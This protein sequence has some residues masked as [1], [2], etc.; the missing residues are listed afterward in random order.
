MIRFCPNCET[1]RPLTETFCE[2]SRDGS[3]CH[4]DL[5]TEEV[6]APGVPPTSATT[7]PGGL[8][9]PNGHAVGQGDLICVEC[10]ES[11]ATDPAPPPPQDAPAPAEVTVIEGWRLG[12]RLAS[13][14]AVRERFLSTRD[15]D[16]RSGVL[17]LY[18]VGSEPD[19]AVY[20]I[21]RRLPREHVPEIL[22]TGRW[23]D[24]A[25]EVTEEI[26]GG[27]FSSVNLAR[28]GVT[29]V[30]AVTEQL[31][32][33]LNSLSE[34]GLRHRDLRPGAVLVRATEPLDLVIGGF[35]SARLSEFDLD[36]VSPLE[37][38]RYSAPETVAGGVAAASDWWSLGMLLLEGITGGACFD[39]V[40]DQAFLIH[41][42][43]N[44]VT[45]PGGL[46]P[47][48]ELLLRGL[49]ARD[50]N[51]RWQWPQ[52][53]AWLS[54]EAV[55]APATTRPQPTSSSGPAITLGNIPHHTA[56]AFALA[57]ANVAHWDEARDKFARGAV[58][59][60]AADAGFESK[61][62][63]AL[64][65]IS[66]IEGLSDDLRLSLALKVLHPIMPLVVRGNILSPGWLLD[67]PADGYEI[68]TGAAP[69]FL[70]RLGTE[71]WLT[72]LKERVKAV[73]DR[74]AQ[75]E[76]DL[77]EEDLRGHLL[78]TSVPRFAALWET[79]RRLMPESEH[80]GIAALME[81]RQ[82]SD[83][84][85]ILLLAASVGQFRPATEILD[86]AERESSTAGIG[87]FDRT[88]AESQLARPRRELYRTLDET[89]ENF[90]RCGLATADDWADRFRVNRRMPLARALALLSI[91]KERWK[92]PPKQ[93]YVSTLLDFFSKKI[94]GGI[95]RGP[96]TRMLIG[97][98]AARIDLCELG[99]RRTPASDIIAHLLARGPHTV[100]LDPAAFAAADGL[101]R[102]IRS[103]HSHALLYRRDTGIDGL[104]M[105]FP[106]L[107]MR[108][109]RSNTKP[110]IAPVLL[111]P[112][113]I[114]PEVGNRGHV[115]LAFGRDHD[116]DPDPDLV[117]LNP[118]FEGII[119]IQHAGEWLEA[120]KE[121][122]SRGALSVDAV[123]D[124]FGGLAEPLA[125]E[126]CPLPGKDTKV[127]AHRRELSPSAVL[128]HLTF[129]G[130]AIVK[131]LNDLR[132]QPPAGTGLEAALR[133][134]P[135]QPPPANAPVRVPEVERYFT[136]DSDPSQ[137]ESV[138][139]ARSAPGLVI[140][141]PPGTGKSQTIVNM[142][143]DAIGRG[144][145]LL[146]IC[147]KQAALDV[148][149]K[150]LE[151]EG[152]ENRFV[153][154]S[155]VNRDRMPIVRGVREQVEAIH[156][157]PPAGSPAWR[158]ERIRAAARIEALES[159]LNGHHEALHR[160][161][162]ATGLTYR[163]LLGELIALEAGHAAP[164]D[165]SS[166]RGELGKLDPAQVATLE[167]TCGPLAKYWLP[168]KF[169]DSAL[170]VLKLFSADP[171]TLDTFVQT[172][173]GLVAAE[174]DRD[175]TNE[176]TADADR[177]ED[178][179]P[180]R[181]WLARH[182]GTFRT[183]SDGFCA[184]LPRLLPL[185]RAGSPGRD[186][187]TTLIAEL[188]EVAQ[189]FDEIDTR[190]YRPTLS[191][192]LELTA[193]RELTWL[194]ATAAQKLA[195]P[196]LFGK[197][198]PMRWLAT[199]RLRASL[200]SMDLAWNDTTVTAVLA[201]ARLERALRPL[202]DRLDTTVKAL[203]NGN[204]LS[205]GRAPDTLAELASNLHAVLSRVGDV[206][207]VINQFPDRGR[208]ESTAMAGN[209]AAFASFF[210]RVERSIRRCEARI[211]SLTALEA[212]GPF[213]EEAW[214]EARRAQIRVDAPVTQPIAAI[215]NALPTL[216]PYQEFRIRASR[217]G[218][219][220]LGLFRKLRAKET[221]LLKIPADN[222]DG[223][224]R[225]SLSRE[226]RLAWKAR[227]QTADSAVLLSTDEV[228]SKIR[229]LATA[230]SEI[231][232]A[233]RQLL[234]NDIDASHVRSAREWEPVTRLTG[235][236][237][238]RLREFIERGA[239]LGLMVL[240]PVWLMT[241]DVASR[242][243]LP[244]A[245]MFD[246]VIFDEASQMPVEYALPTLFR[247]KIVVVSGDEKQMPP[248]AFFSSK[249]END[250]AALFDG[251]EPDESA[252]EEAR[253]A[254]QETWN[255]REIKDCPDLLHLARVAMP[256]R[257]LQVHYRSTYRE[258]IG[259]SN[260]SFYANRLSV[261][262]K[263][264]D[265]VVRQ[266][267]PIEMIRS[268]GLYQDQSN[269]GEARDVVAYLTSLWR[270]GRPPSVGV[271]TFNRKQADLIEE[272]IEEWAEENDQFRIALTRE[273][274][275]N[276]A[277]EDMGFFVKNVEN[278]QGDERD[279]IIFS[280]TFG[281]NSQD[282]FRR[283]FGVLG[284]SGGERRLNV[285]IT[286]ARQ[287]VVMVT[288][289]PIS[290]ISDL[291][292]TR[293]KPTIP[294]DYLQA[295]MEYARLVSDGEHESARDLLERMVTERTSDR[296]ARTGDA[297]GFTEAVGKFLDELGFPVASAQDGGAFGLDFAIKSPRTGLYQV[298]I[299]CDGP[300]HRLLASARAREVWRPHVL[301]KAIP[302][303]HRVSSHAWV[304]AGSAEKERLRAAVDSAF[305]TGA[306]SP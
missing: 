279:V 40:N 84:E 25:F 35:G 287:K 116:S 285:A 107:V 54:G 154:V 275:R 125:R 23:Q 100:N 14:G 298:G 70:R 190:P 53:R 172:L 224:I 82:T 305:R 147:Q 165:I 300:R 233:N 43:T 261:P 95:L 227:M 185:F 9:C 194:I 42:V 114:I 294:R 144:K 138:V 79:K 52:V 253:D 83:E 78:C 238:L 85:L 207:E 293:R 301:R 101:E 291:L 29:I 110:R 192:K 246:T 306:T 162:E 196:S 159:D 135:E 265:E 57:A 86:E 292:T 198:N 106:F 65:Q 4:W 41:V 141:G 176:Q 263:H 94:S 140:E 187:G 239:D 256:S 11:V 62:Q 299:E 55:E 113:R 120:A 184:N 276:D 257:M 230:D 297:D 142:V 231:R 117:I 174:K 240:R 236:R 258:L 254:F 193:D 186:R 112:M 271:V 68:V 244:K 248:T 87:S 209:S 30:R 180:Y 234:V 22:A 232:G 139:E 303:I 1:E 226:A 250:E 66:H 102:R 260:A 104:Y 121:L 211:A 51:E 156:A 268:D 247:S 71:P 158:R 189:S 163:A 210:D 2:G 32:R 157:R 215:E 73:R 5:S 56:S 302:H 133:L 278:V 225:T 200:L 223:V 126:L 15:A 191:A 202:R 128:F 69:D 152:L 59:T 237:S 93:A 115:K 97:K 220:E 251:E 36:I 33:A 206:S 170:S 289:M 96:L 161:D 169:E 103:L 38:S 216:A 252:T 129:M 228:T 203:F 288:S 90:A 175:E 132:G 166:L 218:P 8:R 283:N 272:T 17:T 3:A 98:S 167:E 264:P 149:R 60:W 179:F 111:W 151:K 127:E 92:E 145:S 26:G 61:M 214:L 267:K 24:R 213:I 181:D 13:S 286:R 37:T 273:R 177:I 204:G 284:Q 67:H 63:S 266:H 221:A 148:V 197:L 64:R 48:T 164:L 242:V 44:G 123:M 18:A 160:V 290:E 136:A 80:P 171:G 134:A 50:R 28:G 74:A 76:I 108:D 269:A 205:P 109:A 183:L 10:G 130:Q 143:A 274:D 195:R 222:L 173:S 208:L 12:R 47:D 45:I 304:H 131:D 89:I 72:R 91:P 99:T 229:A 270:Q 241:P 137:E 201:A 296:E 122:L 188:A 27:P 146:V 21:L 217:L 19:P 255:R 49:L 105:G 295:Y 212:L 219:T 150:R 245:G 75:L 182:E 118:A 31:G 20:E 262:V 34:A 199:R 281:R 7:L 243:L 235:Q 277:G 16:S 46:E 119:G 178:P 153:M 280:S 6:R 282:V 124:A 168:S 39:G 77:N 249:V 88:V 58:T 259:F 81:R 155:D